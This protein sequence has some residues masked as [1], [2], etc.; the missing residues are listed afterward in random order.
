MI[1][2]K[3]IFID[4]ITGS[5]KSTT[6]H[7][8]ARQLEKNNIKVKWYYEE[9]MDNP[10]AE[11]EKDKNESELH[12]VERFMAT[13]PAQRRAFVDKVKHDDFVYIV[14]SFL[15]Q[16]IIEILLRSDIERDRIKKYCTQL[17]DEV[18]SLNP[19]V[20]HFYQE[21]VEKSIRR[22]WK[23]RGDD[24]KKWFLYKFAKCPYCYNRNLTGENGA[25]KL[26]DDL[27]D[28]SLE[29]FNEFNYQKLQIENSKQDWDIYRKQVL[30]FLNVQKVDEMFF[31]ESYNQYCGSFSGLKFHINEKRL[32]V[33]THWPNLK[34][35]PIGNDEFE[36]E[37][38]PISFQFLR[39]DNGEIDSLKISK[40][41]CWYN[42]GDICKRYEHLTLTE[43]E[44][45][46]FCGEFIC[47]KENLNRKIIIIDGSLY[48]LR[49]DESKTEL[50]PLSKN[51]LVQ[52]GEIVEFRFNFENRQIHVNEKSKEEY[53]LFDSVLNLK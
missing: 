10:F 32:C 35:F 43:S 6:A 20:I 49:T 17:I 23:R 53:L 5:G 15:F 7:Y 45:K 9:E 12:F 46:M 2:T 33:N 22:N 16:D 40:A 48:Y 25:I 29:L 38:F 37:G 8:I 26:W 31:H 14:E 50:L 21:D 24:W 30:D 47:E 36:I 11:I 39:D 4:G 13:A 19:V 1:N 34:L 42:E 51:R 27:T 3:L 41:L 44:M 52:E 28:I 18:N